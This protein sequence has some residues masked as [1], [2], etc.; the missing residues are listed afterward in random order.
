MFNMINVLIKVGVILSV[1]FFIRGP[2][3]AEWV[4][5]YMGMIHITGYLAIIMYAIIRFDLPLKE[6]KS[7]NYKDL[8]KNNFYLVS[9][10]ISVHLQQSFVLF[11]LAKW[12]SSGMLYAYTVGDKIIWSVRLLIISITNAI[13]PKAAVAFNESRNRFLT[14]K[15]K[16][17][18]FIGICFVSVSLLFLVCAPLIIRLYTGEE[19]Q[20]AILFL[21]LMSL[22]PVLAALN[23]LNIIHLLI[24][25]CNKQ[26][27]Q[28]GIQLLFTSLCLTAIAIY[29]MNI[30]AIGIYAVA[31]EA[32]AL[33]YYTWCINKKRA[34]IA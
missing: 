11:A 19:N 1:I 32:L 23:A 14:M 26:I 13:Y 4:N 30:Y 12:G 24:S 29:L 21:R 9:N 2:Q 33:L 16:Y 31:M 34:E 25:E 22:S 15:K 8:L 28:I 10:S 17:N 3:D 20:T 18:R 6:F 27:L 5:F 7:I